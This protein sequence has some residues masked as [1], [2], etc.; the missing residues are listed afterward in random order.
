MS[1]CRRTD[2]PCRGSTAGR[3]AACFTVSPCYPM[4]RQ[5]VSANNCVRFFYSTRVEQVMELDIHICH[6]NRRQHFIPIFISLCFAGRQLFP[7]RQKSFPLCGD[8]SQLDEWVQTQKHTLRCF[9]EQRC[10]ICLHASS[11]QTIH[12]CSLFIIIYC[13]IICFTRI[14]WKFLTLSSPLIAEVNSNNMTVILL[15]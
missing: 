9:R 14:L 2:D 11:K 7:K 1:C 5:T 12:W 4:Q 10:E 15:P 13:V 3:A 8:W 6:P